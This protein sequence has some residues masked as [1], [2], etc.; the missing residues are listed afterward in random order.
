MDIVLTETFF[1]KLLK[2]KHNAILKKAISQQQLR[3]EAA[4]AGAA[5]LGVMWFN[6][7]A[8]LSGHLLQTCQD[9]GKIY[10]TGDGKREKRREGERKVKEVRGGNTREWDSSQEPVRRNWHRWPSAEP[11]TFV[12]ITGPWVE[13][14]ICTA[15]NPNSLCVNGFPAPSWWKEDNCPSL[16]FWLCESVQS[17]RSL[18]ADIF[19]C[20]CRTFLMV[21]KE[22]FMSP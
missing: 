10:F 12:C 17:C 15:L 5:D 18:D 14:R 22:T 7:G 16:V 19:S 2:S 11:R 20:G 1:Q 6:S 13:T 8:L 3:W 21:Q 9:W 4:T